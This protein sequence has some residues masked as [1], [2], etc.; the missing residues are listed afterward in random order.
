MRDGSDTNSAA[1]ITLNVGGVLV[2]VII[3]SGASCSIDHSLWEKMK[4]EHI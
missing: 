4:A 1:K 2:D 3:D